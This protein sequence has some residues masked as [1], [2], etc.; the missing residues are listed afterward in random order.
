M[1]GRIIGIAGPTVSVRRSTMDASSIAELVRNEH[2]QII[3]TILVH[4]ERDQASGVLS[5]DAVG[6]GSALLVIA[7]LGANTGLLATDVHVAAVVNHVVDQKIDTV[8]ARTRKRPV[9]TGKVSPVDALLFATVLACLLACFLPLLAEFGTAILGLGRCGKCC[10][11]QRRS[12]SGK[13]ASFEQLGDGHT[14][15]L[16]MPLHHLRPR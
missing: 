15:L 16:L 4:L 8:M 12:K 11:R 13:R 5:Y 3:A 6:D 10:C 7:N 2:P 14:R 9:A 1:N